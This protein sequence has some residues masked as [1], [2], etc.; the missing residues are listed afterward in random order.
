[1]VQPLA[2]LVAPG[3]AAFG[4]GYTPGTMKSYVAHAGASLLRSA[5][6]RTL[7]IDDAN[8]QESQVVEEAC[9]LIAVDSTMMVESATLKS[10]LLKLTTQYPLARRVFFGNGGVP[11]C[12]GMGFVSYSE[13][14]D[15][16]HLLSRPRFPAAE[17][18]FEGCITP[19]EYLPY[20]T[21]EG[22]RFNCNFCDVKNRSARGTPWHSERFGQ[23]LMRFAEA[24]FGG[25]EIVDSAFNDFPGKVADFLGAWERR[26]GGGKHLSAMLRLD[27]MQPSLTTRLVDAGLVNAAFGIEAID[28]RMSR[29]A[30]KAVGGANLDHLRFLREYAAGRVLVGASFIVGFPGQTIE[31]A[32]RLIEWLLDGEGAQLIDVPQVGVLT[33]NTAR[34]AAMFGMA[35]PKGA[36]S[37]CLSI[38]GSDQF[39]SVVDEFVRRREAARPGVSRVSAIDLLPLCN[40]LRESPQ[41]VIERLREWNFSGTAPRFLGT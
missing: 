35:S 16:C 12:E 10:N 34:M 33:I 23:D 4:G 20:L 39:Q 37:F 17:S 41:V 36:T 26:S 14:D 11:G 22:C 38:P 25:L 31:D 7:V 30:G 40:E 19:G 21:Y 32:E 27:Q 15:L 3:F 24:S 18:L 28:P 1:M 5:G 2:I 13:F 29:A 6:Y 9:S 8:L